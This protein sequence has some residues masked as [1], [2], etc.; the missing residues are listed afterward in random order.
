MSYVLACLVP[1]LAEQRCKIALIGW[2]CLLCDTSLLA[3]AASLA[4]RG[5]R[6]QSEAGEL[7][8]HAQREPVRA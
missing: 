1:I 8:L 2:K 6:R 3:G 7:S 4:D 5:S